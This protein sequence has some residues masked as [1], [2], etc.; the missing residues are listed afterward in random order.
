MTQRILTYLLTHY[1]PREGWLPL[2]LL[3]GA[4]GCLIWSV[5]GVGWVPEDGI[6]VPTALLGLLLGASLAKRPLS[7][8]PAWL[9][10]G[11]YGLLANLLWLG[12]LW[13]PWGYLLGEWALLRRFWL[14]RGAV[15]LDRLL[16]WLQA[17]LAGDSS[18]ETL[19]FALGLGLLSWFLA[20]Y[21]GW[22]AYRQQRPLNALLIMGAALAINGYYGAAPYFPVAL[23]VAL[24]ALL[25]ALLHFDQLQQQWESRLVDYSTQ[26]RFDLMLHAGL[27]ALIL[28]TFAYL[29]PVF[30]PS[31]VA[32]A[33]L[34]QPAV[35][36][37]EQTLE[38]VFGGVRPP[39]GPL[40]EEVGTAP[41]SPGGP[42]GAGIL[43]RAYLLGNA[44]ELSQTVV[45]T[46]TLNWADPP[47]PDRTRLERWRAL[48][49]DVYTG[50]G[51]A[52]SEERTETV[53]PFDPIPLPPIAEQTAI[54][55]TVHWLFDERLIR[56]TM[57]QPL[58]FDQETTTRW[59]GQTDLARVARTREGGQVYTA[60]SRHTNAPAAALRT[61]TLAEIEPVILGRYTNL[62]ASLPERVGQLA[63]EIAGDQP[64]PYDQAQ[65]LVAFLNQYP[66]TLDVGVPPAGQD[67]VDYFLFEAQTGY[68]DYYA[69]AMVVLARSLGLPA[70]LV[71][72]YLSPPPEATGVYTVRQI[73]S[74]SWVEI[75]FAGYGWVEF[76]PTR[77]FA[78]GVDE[79]WETAVPPAF[80]DRDV[81]L[82][83]TGPP[84]LPDQD[85]AGPSWSFWLIG[86]LIIGLLAL[87]SWLLWRG[88]QTEQDLRQMGIVWVYGRLHHHIRRWGQP[89]PPQQTPAEFEQ[90]LTQRLNTWATSS[91]RQ[92]V[93]DQL[94]PHLIR[95]VGLYNETRYGG[96]GQ[97]SA[98]AT[99]ALW[100][101]LRRPLW[102]LR[103]WQLLDK[104]RGTR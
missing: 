19:S 80:V 14:Q 37:A 85:P 4:V 95:L 59:R 75:Y 52:I 71:V 9:L 88:W 87:P 12:R 5:L 22:A 50:R 33:L 96:R 28:L 51:W 35:V 74:H 64:T 44:P 81:S 39:A 41:G 56:Y 40:A 77:P 62:P 45:M 97:P 91:R 43:P 16:G 101:Q 36:Q 54:S 48:S 30:N 82:P 65:A 55:Q 23:F 94:Y 42:G 31:Q 8:L 26:I 34:R 7:P 13:P 10:I 90:A 89:I 25:A 67:V 98:Q 11:A 46:A 63:Q 99:R 47:P 21:V 24:A 6:V 58:R 73:E 70:R 1:R 78:P 38:R 18:Q 100:H 32:R 79:T 93:V 66:Y 92:Q 15:F 53:P 76:E 104:I 2:L 60:I 29:L 20:A 17:V 27:T 49:Y 61:A 83:D 102:W 57:G 68:C 84:P 69:S 72:G 103:L 3:F 86:L